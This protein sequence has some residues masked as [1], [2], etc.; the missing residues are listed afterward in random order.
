MADNGFFARLGNLWR[1]FLSLWISGIEIVNGSGNK[2]SVPECETTLTQRGGDKAPRVQT[3]TCQQVAAEMNDALGVHARIDLFKPEL[4]ATPKGAFAGVQQ[5]D[6][7]YYEGRTVNSQ[8]VVF[9]NEKNGQSKRLKTSTRT[10]ATIR[11]RSGKSLKNDMST[12]L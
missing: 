11:P 4:D 10:C 3:D 7:Q 1:G 2:Q 6:A 5:T 9:G 12:F 8:G